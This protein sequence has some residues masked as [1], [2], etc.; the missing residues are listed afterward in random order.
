[1]EYGN[2]E[3]NHLV[4]RTV[5]NRYHHEETELT[6]DN[7]NVNISVLGKRI[8]EG[9]SVLDVG[10]GE[11]KA[12]K[13]LLPKNCLMYGIEID[14]SAIAY[15][16]EHSGY[17]DIF[18]FNVENPLL[19]EREYKRFIDQNILFDYIIIADVLEHTINPTKVIEEVSKYL[20]YDGEILISIPNV[21]NA[22]IVLN[23]LR[24]RFNYMEAGILDNTHTKYFTKGS[25]VE[26][27][28]DMNTLFPDFKY[29]CQYI[30]GI[31][32]LTNYLEKVK[33]EMPLVFEFIQLNPE[34]SVI[35]N[36]FVMTKRRDFQEVKHIHELLE[37]KRVDLVTVL[38]DYLERGMDDR[39][40]ELIGGVK[41]L[42]N[43]RVILEE[44]AIA[45]EKGWKECDKKLSQSYNEID[46]LQTQ[47]QT[48]FL[49]CKKAEE[50]VQ[51][52]DNKRKEALE[53]WRVADKRYQEAMEGWKE[54]DKQLQKLQETMS[55]EIRK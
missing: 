9:S 43:E 3:V 37:E 34:Y 24:G 6:L 7:L 8:K 25:F 17:E 15:A 42:P 36:L 49:E 39:F 30:G 46:K 27:V 55:G 47:I 18:L 5:E 45:S 10:C 19:S 51:L 38:S 40:I 2:G 16:M 54:C 44:R 13:L 4:W 32:G 22:D 52:C 50:S 1:M 28:A 21:N 35:Q 12:G 29:D 23:L 11:G 53:G 14:E 26:W 33:K 20:K 48:L 41:L 31:Y